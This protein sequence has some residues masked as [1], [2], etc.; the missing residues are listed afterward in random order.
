MTANRVHY[1]DSSGDEQAIPLGTATQVLTS[2]G[3]TSAPSFESPTVDIT[4][5]TEDNTL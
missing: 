1:I 5:S 4:G 3:G 2:N